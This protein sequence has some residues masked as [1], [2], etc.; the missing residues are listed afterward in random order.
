MNFHYATDWTQTYPDPHSASQELC[1]KLQ[2]DYEIVEVSPAKSNV[3]H[4][5]TRSHI[6]CRSC[7][8]NCW[9]QSIWV[10]AQACD[11]Q[12]VRNSPGAKFE[13]QRIQ[14]IRKKD[15]KDERRPKSSRAPKT[16][17]NLCS[18]QH[19]ARLC[20][21]I[22]TIYRRYRRHVMSWIRNIS[23]WWSWQNLVSLLQFGERWRD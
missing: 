1:Q 10:V 3:A 19:F 16:S 15:E 9:A 20:T 21:M 11:G 22:S 17:R 14:R 8:E 23:E 12:E 5:R 2:L 7:R 4:G 13:I 6:S 18:R